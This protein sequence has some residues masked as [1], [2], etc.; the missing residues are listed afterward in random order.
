MRTIE[1]DYFVTY[2]GIDGKQYQTVI[3][4]VSEYK[5]IEKVAHDVNEN[6]NFGMNFKAKVHYDI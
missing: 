4:S 5:A 1:L 6:Q 2:D 3:K